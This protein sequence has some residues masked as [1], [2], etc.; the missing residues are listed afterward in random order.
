MLV[1]ELL[2]HRFAR[3]SAGSQR[4]SLRES[5]RAMVE[6]FE[7]RMTSGE[8]RLVG[9]PCPCGESDAVTVAEICYQ[10]ATTPPRITPHQ[11]KTSSVRILGFLRG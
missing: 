4:A 1:P 8:Y 6:E 9:E 7:G 5:Q 10:A 11:A 2:S 3:A